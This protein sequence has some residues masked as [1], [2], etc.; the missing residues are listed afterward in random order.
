MRVAAIGRHRGEFSAWWQRPRSRQRQQECGQHQSLKYHREKDGLLAQA[1]ESSHSFR[2]AFNKAEFQNFRAAHGF[3]F[4]SEIPR[5]RC[6]AGMQSG[7][8]ACR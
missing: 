5:V 4:S 1:A 6:G 2:I 8:I 3:S 7:A